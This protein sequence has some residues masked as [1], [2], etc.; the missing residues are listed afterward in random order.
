MERLPLVGSEAA[1]MSQEVEGGATMLA[2]S[3]FRRR[4]QGVALRSRS[5]VLMLIAMVVQMNLLTVLSAI[6]MVA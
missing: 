1:A 6:T 3:I 2:V 5:I 4:S